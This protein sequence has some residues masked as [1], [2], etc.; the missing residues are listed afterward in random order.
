[1]IIGDWLMLGERLSL[2]S[3]HVIYK[4]SQYAVH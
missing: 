1:M 4:H 2:G 3:E